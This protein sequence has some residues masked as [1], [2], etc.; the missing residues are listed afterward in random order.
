MD[1]NI[2]LMVTLQKLTWSMMDS[3]G[4]NIKSLGFTISEFEILSHLNAK[5]KTKTQELGRVAK[6]TSGTITHTVNKL[7]EKEF[8]V[9]IP[10]IIK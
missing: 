6:I 1:T 5:G 2:R 3:L 10:L 9:K 8:V 4:K 7:I